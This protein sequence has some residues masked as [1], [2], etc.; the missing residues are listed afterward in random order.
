MDLYMIDVKEIRLPAASSG[1][2]K[3]VGVP[4][5]EK[6]NGLQI[7]RWCNYWEGRDE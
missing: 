7:V 4:T 1:I 2:C 3:H 5:S 6:L